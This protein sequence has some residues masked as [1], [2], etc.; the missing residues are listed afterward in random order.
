MKILVFVLL[1]LGTVSATAQAQTAE[2]VAGR[3]ERVDGASSRVLMGDAH[4]L[5]RSGVKEAARPERTRLYVGDKIVVGSTVITVWYSM[6]GQ[7]AL[8]DVTSHSSPT[9][10]PPLKATADICSLVACSRVRALW[11]KPWLPTMIRT[12]AR[13]PEDHRPIV[14]PP[15]MGKNL[16]R[17]PAS[18]TT[19][20]LVWGGGAGSVSLDG[21]VR[22]VA[23]YGFDVAPRPARRARFTIRVAGVEGGELSWPVVVSDTPVPTLAGMQGQPTAA[24]DRLERALWLLEP[25]Q[26]HKAW[27]LFALSEIVALKDTYLPADLCW[28]LLLAGQWKELGLG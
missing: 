24:A 6:V 21:T 13:G 4:V 7:R 12:G 9:L 2:P 25:G 22:P 5:R 19:V 26:D 14:A 28:R 1:V 8:L 20:A 23:D 10:M 11:E 27:R 16:Q 18:A 17:L 3:I 15:F